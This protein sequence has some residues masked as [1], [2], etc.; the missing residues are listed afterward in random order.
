[1]SKVLFSNLPEMVAEI[2]PGDE[3]AAYIV[4]FKS[5]EHFALAESPDDALAAV[6]RELG[7]EVGNVPLDLVVAA[8]RQL[9][10]AA[11][12]VAAADAKPPGKV[13]LSSLAVVECRAIY[14]ERVF[15]HFP[16]AIHEPGD[17]KKAE[18]IASIML[19]FPDE[20]TSD[21]PPA[22]AAAK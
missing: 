16:Q 8:A 9:P 5:K 2:V 4:K 22:E 3:R 13:N 18:L 12:K 20:F 7:A 17:M 14:R 1:M 10:A 15:G 6:M 11:V 19:A 21:A